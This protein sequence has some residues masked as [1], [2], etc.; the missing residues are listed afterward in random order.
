MRMPFLSMP[1]HPP[2]TPTSRARGLLMS[3]VAG[4][5]CLGAGGLSAQSS[6]DAQ[7]CGAQ[8]AT[9]R[10]GSTNEIHAGAGCA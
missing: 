10:D 1:F 4:A 8:S 3:L 2:A 9:R 7:T 6:E 5:A